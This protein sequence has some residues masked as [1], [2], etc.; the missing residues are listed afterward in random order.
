MWSISIGSDVGTVAAVAA[1]AATLFRPYINIHKAGKLN[2]QFIITT[3]SILRAGGWSLFRFQM[4][5]LVP[6]WSWESSTWSLTWESNE[7]QTS[8]T[9]MSSPTTDTVCPFQQAATFSM[10]AAT[11]LTAWVTRYCI[12]QPSGTWVRSSKELIYRVHRHQD[13]AAVV[14]GNLDRYQLFGHI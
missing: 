3:F 8:H 14:A 9:F 7:R 6:V 13:Y 2:S 5:I 11:K 10:I 1:L 12:Y 4:S